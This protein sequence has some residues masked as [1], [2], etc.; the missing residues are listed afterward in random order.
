M[1][2]N[3]KNRLFKIS[4]LSLV[5]TGVVSAVSASLINNNSVDSFLYQTSRF[6]CFC[7]FDQQ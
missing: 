1:K 5:T 6:S 2:K 3:L 4:T 7:K